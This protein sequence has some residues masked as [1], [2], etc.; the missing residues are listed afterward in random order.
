MFHDICKYRLEEILSFF[1]F[2][3]LSQSLRAVRSQLIIYWLSYAKKLPMFGIE[4]QISGLETRSSNP[5]EM[6]VC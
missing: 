5:G 1:V 6:T 2:L 4:P 3:V